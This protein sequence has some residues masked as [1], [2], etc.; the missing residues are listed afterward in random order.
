VDSVSDYKKM[1]SYYVE[2]AKAE[3]ISLIYIRFANH[4]ALL[5]AGQSITTY[6][7]DANKGF[8]GFATEVHNLIKEAA[9]GFLCI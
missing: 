6:H 1:V 2:N 4:E 3:N 7:V 5:D 8:E 9:K